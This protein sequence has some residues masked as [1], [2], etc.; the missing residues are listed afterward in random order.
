MDKDYV[1]ITHANEDDYNTFRRSID[2]YE[3]PTYDWQRRVESSSNRDGGA[4]T[5][6]ERSGIRDFERLGEDVKLTGGF[7]KIG[8]DD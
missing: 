1:K 7:L 8:T 4:D 2:A 3:N 5:I 6:L